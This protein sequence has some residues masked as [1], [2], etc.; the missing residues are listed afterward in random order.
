MYQMDHPRDTLN[1]LPE[2][3]RDNANASLNPVRD[4]CTSSGSLEQ[5]RALNGFL[6]RLRD[7]LR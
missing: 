5:V 7:I 2:Q 4:T 3:V 6:N 1:R